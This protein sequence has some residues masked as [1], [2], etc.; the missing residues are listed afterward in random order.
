MLHD[1]RNYYH[2]RFPFFFPIKNI[3][4][5]VYQWLFGNCFTCKFVGDLYHYST[6]STGFCMIIIIDIIVVVVVVM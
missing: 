1:A 2:F 4:K 3:V 5:A 6:I